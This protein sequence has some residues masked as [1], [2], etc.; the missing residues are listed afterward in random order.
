[1]RANALVVSLL[2]VIVVLG[3]LAVP[4]VNAGAAYVKTP[5]KTS[6]KFLLYL[7]ADNSLDVYAGAHH[8]SVVE[9]DF[10]ELISVGSTT[11]AAAYVLVDR[12]AGPANLFKVLPGKMQELTDFALN[13]KEANMGDPATLRS[14]VSYTSKT[15]PS[16]HTLLIFWDH[17]SP[18]GVAWDDHAS[19]APGGTDFLSQWEVV[20]ALSG[21]K[22]DVIGADECNV[23][24]TEVAYEYAIGLQTEYLVAA[25]TYTGWRG[26]PYDALLRELTDH[27]SMTPREVAAMMVEQTQILLDKPPYS[28][29]RINSHSAI[30]LA[31]MPELVASLKDL[32]NLLTPNMDIYAGTVSKA[33]G[34]AQYCYGANAINVIDLGT[35]VKRISSEARSQGVL[36][37]CSAVLASLDAAIVSMHATGS[38][39]HMLTGLGIGFPNHSWEMSSYY[40]SFAFADQ[41]WMDFLKAYWAAAGSI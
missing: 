40:P 5:A 39:D 6:W 33:R 17:G 14:F 3:I 15:A 26:F 18:R 13:D 37:A 22:V 24:H 38:T 30:D 19:D 34:A 10:Q 9:S 31:K 35:F 2:A 20:Q 28:G 12:Y 16:E 25:E 8:V 4:C 7:D 32:T 41:G 23:G 1:L 11:D 21:Y 36:D 29:E 27:P